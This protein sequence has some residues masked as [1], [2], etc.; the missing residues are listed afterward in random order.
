MRT[1]KKVLPIVL[2]LIVVA[3]LG[4]KTDVHAT[5][6]SDL[7]HTD[8]TVTDTMIEILG[9][10]GVRIKGL[11]ADPSWPAMV[12]EIDSP[13]CENVKNLIQGKDSRYPTY[14]WRAQIGVE[15]W[16]MECNHKGVNTQRLLDLI[17]TPA[18][19]GVK[20][21]N[22]GAVTYPKSDSYS[23]ILLLGSTL[24]DFK[25]R[26]AFLNTIVS[27]E[28]VKLDST[29]VYIL[30]GKRSF[31]DAEKKFL[32]SDG[33]PDALR[34]L[35]ADL[36]KVGVEWLYALCQKDARLAALTPITV[37][38]ANPVG[39][40]AATE[41]TLALFFK[42]ESVSQDQKLLGVSTHIFALY[43][44]LIF[45][46]I[47]FKSGFKGQVEICAPALVGSD[48]DSYSMDRKLAML[49]DNLSR[50]F[51]EICLYKEMSG[52]YPS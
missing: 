24:G 14:S 13:S 15:R 28:R 34:V 25:S 17:L 43:Q 19:A 36:E 30:T 46:R 9:Q 52:A 26:V 20:G 40:R 51:Y 41:T 37:D 39:V 8:G 49:L 35:N 44:Y 6:V 50:I 22:M 29:T 18:V 4:T 27:E 47:A 11:P 1:I 3:G 12:A 5:Q 38:D 7:I 42:Q 32:T 16:D 2:M 45:K 10:T 33:T 31:N 23:K 21:L 48:R